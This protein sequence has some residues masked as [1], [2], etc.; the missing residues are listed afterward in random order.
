MKDLSKEKRAELINLIRKVNNP[1]IRLKFI[2]SL[3]IEDVIEVA[4]NEEDLDVVYA[5]RKKLEKEDTEEVKKNIFKLAKAKDWQIRLLSVELLP[6]KELIEMAVNEENDDVVKA[7]LKRLEIDIVFLEDY[8]GDFDNDILKRNKK[9]I[10]EVKNNIS[11]LANAKHQ[12]IRA[13]SIRFLPI[14]NF[15]EM[16]LN[17]E[18]PNVVYMIFEMFIER[19]PGW[20]KENACKLIKAKSWI[21]RHSIVEFLVKDELIEMLENEEHSEIIYAI[22]EKLKK[23]DIEELRKNAYKLTKSE[24]WR[25]RQLAIEFL[26]VNELI[27]MAENEKLAEVLFKILER[28]EKEKDTEEIAK[29]AY[30]LAK[31]KVQFFRKFATD[32]LSGDDLI[33]MAKIEAD[34]GVVYAILSKLKKEKNIE[35]VKKNAIKLARAKN[36]Q[37]QLLAIEFLEPDILSEVAEEGEEKEIVQKII[38]I[39]N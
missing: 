33:E 30:K 38:D 7:I 2:N 10:E 20:L 9:D 3:T 11:K 36:F 28:L 35:L 12:R 14:N 19:N 26:S 5:I 18:Y 23:E 32:F 31:S 37:I 27:E 22:F 1:V 15:I 4:V 34:I 6:A 39:L 16:L 24:D 13:F 29:N 17:E 8:R 21:V 25:I